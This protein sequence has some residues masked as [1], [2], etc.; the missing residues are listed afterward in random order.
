MAPKK[1]DFA[2][3]FDPTQHGVALLCAGGA[4]RRSAD[5][6]SASATAQPQRDLRSDSWSLNEEEH[7]RTVVQCRMRGQLRGC[8]DNLRDCICRSRGRGRR[9]RSL[10]HGKQRDVHRPRKPDACRKRLLSQLFL[11]LSRACLGKCDRF[12]CKNGSEKVRFSHQKTR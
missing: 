2:H 4:A 9:H 8:A 10:F 3:R 6:S 12:R 7:D 1:R 5:C 11:W